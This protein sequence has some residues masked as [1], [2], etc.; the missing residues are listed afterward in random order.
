MRP[1]CLSSETFVYRGAKL[2]LKIFEEY[3]DL[4]NK[5]EE[6]ELRGFT[7][8]SLNK[9]IAFSFMFRGLS[10]DVVPVLYQIHNLSV[11][12]YYYFKLDNLDYSLFPTEQEVLLVSGSNFEIIEI[13][14]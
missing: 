2:P 14:E 6:L 13:S 3:K 5:N 4:K 7:S 1:G 9:E 12:G 10:K 11:N 8:T